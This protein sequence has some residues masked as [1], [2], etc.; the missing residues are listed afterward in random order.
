[1]ASGAKDVMRK[2]ALAFALFAVVVGPLGSVATALDL[3]GRGGDSAEV[4]ACAAERAPIVE[5]EKQYEAVRRS[6]IAAAVGEGVKQGAAFLAGALLQRYV[7]N[8]PGGSRISVGVGLLNPANLSEAGKLQIPGVTT[9]AGA[10]AFAGA[11]LGGN[12]TRAIAAMA[13]VVA[14]A[15]SVEAYVRLKQEE[16]DGDRYRMANSIDEDARRQIEV[17]RAIAAEESALAQ[18]RARQVSDY[19]QHLASASN[20]QDRRALGRERNSL[21][22]AIQKDVDLTGGVVGQQASLAKTYTQGR[23]MTEGRSEAD[24]LGGQAPAYADTASTKPLQLP[25]AQPAKGAAPAG[26]LAALAKKIAPPPPPPPPAAPAPTYVAIRSTP[27]RSAPKAGAM[28][29]TNL[30]KDRQVQPSGP[31]SDD[32][33]WVSVD[34][35]RG[36]IGYVK[37]SD[38]AKAAQGPAG[39]KSAQ[40]PAGPQLAPP[41]N[42]REHNRAVLTA[43]EEGPDRL[44]T[45]LT[46]VQTG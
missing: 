29:L 1:M 26:K 28:V 19:R 38:L 15:G 43:R 24:V 12:S 31:A 5:R 2:G 41:Q 27:V 42:I 34:T 33:A 16:A 18:C 8:I 37:V 20:D 45:L 7:S 4:N 3:P 22:G 30:A 17:N 36:V 10:G 21:Q 14:I 23:A 32:P 40:G 46:N 6:H 44:K 13:V 35:G 25:P 39:G 9:A 11:A